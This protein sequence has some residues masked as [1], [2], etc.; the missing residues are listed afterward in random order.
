MEDIAAMFVGTNFAELFDETEE[1]DW[2]SQV[3]TI[4]RAR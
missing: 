3:R 1:E 4:A 2:D